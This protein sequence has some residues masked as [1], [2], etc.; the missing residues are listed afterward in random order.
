MFKLE[1]KQKNFPQIWGKIAGEEQSGED[2][3]NICMNFSGNYEKS[4]F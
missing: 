1:N 4:V 2:T 3:Q